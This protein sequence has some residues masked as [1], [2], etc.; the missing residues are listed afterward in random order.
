MK[1]KPSIR[2]KKD[3]NRLGPNNP[4]IKRGAGKLKGD[5][6]I[7]AIKEAQKDPQFMK[8][9]KKFIKATTSIRKLA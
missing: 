2:N 9:I 5:K 1:K 7:K 3:L 4:C 6:L 8:E